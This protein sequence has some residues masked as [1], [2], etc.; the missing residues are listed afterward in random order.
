[1]LYDVLASQVYLG[2]EVKLLLT[3]Q[4]LWQQIFLSIN[5]IKL[6]EQFTATMYSSC[7]FRNSEVTE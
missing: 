2:R 1:M 6:L 5:I 3:H 4:D 7:C